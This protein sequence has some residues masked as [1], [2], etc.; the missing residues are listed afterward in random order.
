[1]CKLMKYTLVL[2]CL[3]ILSYTVLA[4]DAP[5]TI[6]HEIWGEVVMN[7]NPA[8]D[9]LVVKALIDGADHAQAST[10]IDGLF[11][12]M[13]VGADSPL[14]YNDDPDCNVHWGNDEACI[15]CTQDVDCIEGP[16]DGDQIIVEVDG[17]QAMPFIK[18]DTGSSDEIEIVTP[19]GDWDKAGCVDMAD[20]GFFVNNYGKTSLT[21]GWDPLYD[22]FLDDVVDMADF[23]Y[24]VNSYGAG[25]Q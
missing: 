1:M 25:C 8:S 17:D 22:L 6:P 7:G 24:F 5:P 15:P 12:V 21:I 13:V 23:G 4:S 20:F 14:T 10:T 18:L 19:I 16:Q 3:L 11:N 2:F 9:G